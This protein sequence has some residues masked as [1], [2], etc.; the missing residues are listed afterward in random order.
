MLL[1]DEPALGVDLPGREALIE[2][3]D[4]LAGTGGPTTVHAAHTLEELPS[5]TSHAMLLAAGRVVASGIAPEVL[6]D[7]PLSECFGAA[8]VVERR[9]R[10]YSARAAGSWSSRLATSRPEPYPPVTRPPASR[11]RDSGR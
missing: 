10:R 2:T 4:E 9:G 1:L 8:F 3:L 11:W 5:L 7:E 6:I